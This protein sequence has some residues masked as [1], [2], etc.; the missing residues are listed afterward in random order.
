M[1]ACINTSCCLRWFHPV[2]VGVHGDLKGWSFPDCIGGGTTDNSRHHFL[3]VI[4][5]TVPLLEPSLQLLG[6]VHK[7]REGGDG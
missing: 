7:L 5:L 1:I 2:C 3:F 6:S 4:V